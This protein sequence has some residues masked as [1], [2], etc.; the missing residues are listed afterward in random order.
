MKIQNGGLKLKSPE[1]DG[2]NPIY[3][4]INSNSGRLQ[5]F[6]YNSL[7]GFM[8][9]LEVNEA[10]SEYLTLNGNK[11]MNPVTSFIL[12]FAIITPKDNENLPDY[13]RARKAS[14]S[15]N[16][17]FEEAKL[18]QRIWKTSISGGR[19]EICPP[20]ANFSLFD[21]DNA[22]N[23]LQFLQGKTISDRNTKNVFDYLFSYIN[24]NI[25]SEIGIIV[26]PK[27]E[28]STTFSDFMKRPDGSDFYGLTLNKEIKSRAEICVAAQASRL[29]IDIGVIH[30]D[31]HM[32]NALIFLSKY[33][34]IECV[35]I[36]FGRASD[37]MNDSNDVYFDRIEKK[38]MRNKKDDYFDY[39]FRNNDDDDIK[40]RLVFSILK[41]IADKDKEKNQAMFVYSQPDY[42]QMQWFDDFPR[43][44]DVLLDTFNKLKQSMEVVQTKITNATF[45]AY[46]REGNFVDFNKR[47]NDF[48]VPF[49]KLQ[50]C[51]DDTKKGN[52][53][54]MG[55]MKTKTCKKHKKNK[56]HKK[57]KKHK[58]TRR[59]KKTKKYPL[60]LF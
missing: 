46:E 17:Y 20:V 34:N 37:I 26:M 13:N 3:D 24:S 8:I 38:N 14:E 41:T 16:S 9:T 53:I 54:V 56:K 22:K 32:K 10:D 43:T 59:I 25:E 7:K 52:C 28:R 2:F 39:L 11:F 58:K 42:Y 49:P 48:I 40:K 23:L 21:N 5:V 47:I 60:K 33:N 45:K 35:L 31:L 4:M 19:E 30:F 36:D 44:N 27:V 18:Q 6:T 15:R 51:S 50:S 57:H 12:K 29:L 55:G 1:K